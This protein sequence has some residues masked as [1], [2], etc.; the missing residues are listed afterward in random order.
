MCIIH[1]RNSVDW[2]H[3]HYLMNEEEDEEK[4]NL[5]DGITREKKQFFFAKRMRLVSDKYSESNGLDNVV[6]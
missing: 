6:H 3:P 2:M 4:L 5:K 1:I